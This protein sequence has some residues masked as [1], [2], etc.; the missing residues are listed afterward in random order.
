[1]WGYEDVSGLQFLVIIER[2]MKSP[3]T[4]VLTYI[5]SARMRNSCPVEQPAAYLVH[6]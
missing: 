2:S 4:S 1:M 6:V 5:C 3:Y